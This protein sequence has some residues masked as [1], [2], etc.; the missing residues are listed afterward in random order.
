MACPPDATTLRTRWH[1]S[2]DRL[3][4]YSAVGLLNFLNF[5][6]PD[7]PVESGVEPVVRFVEEGDGCLAQQGAGGGQALM[8]ARITCRGPPSMIAMQP[9]W[10]PIF[11]RCLSGI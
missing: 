4:G 3:M 2:V 10:R 8:P 6:D 1:R 9:N 11:P 7:T 5:P